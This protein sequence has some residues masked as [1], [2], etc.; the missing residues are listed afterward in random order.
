MRERERKRK[1]SRIQ[2]VVLLESSTDNSCK[3]SLR[4][5][6]LTSLI[7]YILLWMWGSDLALVSCISRL[8]LSINKIFLLL[9]YLS[10]IAKDK[11]RKIL[12]CHKRTFL[13][14][15]TKVFI[16]YCLSVSLVYNKMFVSF[17]QFRKYLVC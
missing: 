5:W 4:V 8:R 17:N 3:A 13:Y 12:T 16:L 6:F 14:Q 11:L 2:A 7:N 15:R 1:S 9:K 10:S